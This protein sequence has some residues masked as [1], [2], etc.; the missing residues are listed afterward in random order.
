MASESI[1]V[2][3]NMTTPFSTLA[4]ASPEVAM[5]AEVPVVLAGQDVAKFSSFRVGQDEPPP[6]DRV[7]IAAF[8]A[9]WGD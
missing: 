2:A 5:P 7:D 4:D 9:R 8:F 1:A 6:L 3:S